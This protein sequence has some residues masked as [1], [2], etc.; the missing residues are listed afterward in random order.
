M[1]AMPCGMWNCGK[2][3]RE[4]WI[5]CRAQCK[6]KL[7]IRSVAAKIFALLRPEKIKR[8]KHTQHMTGAFLHGLVHCCN[9]NG[10]MHHILIN[11]L[12]QKTDSQKNERR[13]KGYR[14]RERERKRDER[15]C[16]RDAFICHAK[17][18]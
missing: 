2:F 8:I 17:R 7:I 16:N 10:C 18:L 11:F 14:E 6:R 4:Y 1:N 3:I 15:Q 12:T 13:E 9:F 5:N